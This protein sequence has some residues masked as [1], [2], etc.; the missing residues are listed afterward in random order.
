MI[1]RLWGPTCRL[2]GTYFDLGSHRLFYADVG[3]GPVVV[4]LHG[5]GWDTSLWFQTIALFASRCRII[6][7]DTRG[8]GLSTLPPNDFSIADLA[9][10]V[11]RLLQHLGI[12]TF[13]V[14]GFSQ[15]GMTAQV[16]AS[17]HADNCLG[18]LVA[19]ALAAF[20]LAAQRIMER[21]M[22]A[23][24]DEGAAG[25]AQAAAASIFSSG[26][27]AAHPEEIER[28]Q[29]WRLTLDQQALLRCTR[30]LF[31]FDI[32]ESAAAIA[33]PA[34]VTLG[35]QDALASVAGGRRLAEALPNLRRFEVMPGGHMIPIEQ[36]E[37]F[38]A[39][40]AN[41][42]EDIAGRITTAPDHPGRRE[43]QP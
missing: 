18:L 6:A 32:G 3:A 43:C 28:F 22:A 34:Y 20:P 4:L 38:A 15:G 16:L 33:A 19:G 21:R 31:G 39:L 42:I 36:P 37:R 1:N 12:T 25:A 40:F 13:A 23:F 27:R 35:D 8:H 5:L 9:D 24:A 14:A 41:F 26:F 7:V 30:A 2:P 11:D 29:A 10:D 17:R